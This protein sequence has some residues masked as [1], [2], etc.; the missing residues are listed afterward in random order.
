M[1]TISFE[2]LK[3]ESKAFIARAER[4]S[5]IEDRIISLVHRII[6]KMEEVQG[7]LERIER[8]INEKDKHTLPP[9][10]C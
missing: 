7:N 9:I 1:E 4:A 5:N 10:N 3:K 8:K 6:E 2:E